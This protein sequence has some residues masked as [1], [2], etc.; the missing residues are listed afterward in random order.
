MLNK[1][2]NYND[3]EKIIDI[4]KQ[5]GDF[6]KKLNGFEQYIN[7]TKSTVEHMEKYVNLI[8]LVNISEE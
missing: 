6:N 8:P 3:Y 2:Q 7:R 1:F 4:S 5:D